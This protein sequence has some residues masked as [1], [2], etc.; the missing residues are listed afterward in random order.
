MLY[1]RNVSAVADDDDRAASTVVP[2]DNLKWIDHN[3]TSVTIYFTNMH[4]R[5]KVNTELDNVVLTTSGSTNSQLIIKELIIATQ[6]S[7]D[8]II[9]VVDEV[10]EVYLNETYCDTIASI[11]IT[12]Y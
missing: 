11:N 6:T 4:G 8:T 3:G 1:F 5:G 12:A 7:E 2:V 9:T 10:L